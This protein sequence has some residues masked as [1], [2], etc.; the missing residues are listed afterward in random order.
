MDPVVF[1]QEQLWWVV[2]LLNLGEIRGL[3]IMLG[4]KQLVVDQGKGLNGNG[5]ICWIVSKL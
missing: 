4:E 1:S 3:H 2:E 5:S